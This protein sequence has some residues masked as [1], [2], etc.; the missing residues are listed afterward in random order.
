MATAV[1]TAAASPAWS[2]RPAHDGSTVLRACSP[3]P[4]SWT[5]SRRCSH[6]ARQRYPALTPARAAGEP[7]TSA[8][9]T[10]CSASSP[11]ATPA[12]IP[13]CFPCAPGTAT[14]ATREPSTTPRTRARP[15]RPSRPRRAARA[16]SPSPTDRSA[17][18]CSRASSTWSR[19]PVR[20]S[21]TCGPACYHKHRGIDRRF[22]DLEHRRRACCWPNASRERPRSPTPS[23]FCQALEALGGVELP[24]PAQLVR[25]I[26]AELERVAV[27]LDSIIRHTEGAGQAVAYA[28]MTLHKERILRLRARLCGHRFGRGVVVPGGVTGPLTWLRR[29]PGRHRDRSIRRSPTT[30]GHSWPRLHSSIDCV[31][32]GR[33]RPTAAEATGRSARWG[34][35]RA[36]SRTSGSNGRTGRTRYLGFEPA[37]GLTPVTPWLASGSDRGDPPV[38]PPRPSGPRR[39][40]RSIH[41]PWRARSRLPKGRRVGWVEAP[42]GELL[43]LV[44]IGKGS[45]V[46]VKPRS[47]SFHNLALFA[48]GLP[49]RHLHRLR[50][51]SKPASGC[52]SP[53]CRADGLG[54]ARAARG[55]G[56]H[57]VTHDVPTVTATR[58]SGCRVP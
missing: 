19:P 52:R 57:R 49:G 37:A 7:G 55:R 34:G 43:Y 41:G 3:P 15:D 47:A 14:A 4:G 56:H 40:R 38:V 12:S 10:T 45:P 18:G 9:S 28:R 26:H 20:R 30:A 16:C 29:P 23:A 24:R 27:H 58:L 35:A 22:G 42:Q 36:W 5:R 21:L 48:A 11:S 32:P 33:C 25:V 8:R 1:R 17:Q 50:R 13:S 51:S 6:P 53:G 44:E 31:A 54:A 2:Q 46:R 39:A